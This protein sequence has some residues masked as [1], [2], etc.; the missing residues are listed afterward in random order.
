MHRDQ[1]AVCERDIGQK[2]LVAPH[3]TAW[4]QRFGPAHLLPFSEL[5]GGRTLTLLS[6]IRGRSSTALP[7]AIASVPRSAGPIRVNPRPI[8]VASA[9]PT[10]AGKGS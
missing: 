1:A 7:A 4:D 3:Q 9:S 8:A 6:T 5:R 10:D 2:P